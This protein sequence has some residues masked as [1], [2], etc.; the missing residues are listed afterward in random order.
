[1]PKRIKD[2]TCQERLEKQFLNAEDPTPKYFEQVASIIDWVT[3]IDEKIDKDTGKT[4]FIRRKLSGNHKTLYRV[5]LQSE[6]NSYCYKTTRTLAY[7]VGCSVGT[8]YNAKQAL[9][10]PIEQFAGMSL[11][12]I[13]KVMTSSYA[14]KENGVN[15]KTNKKISDHITSNDIWKYNNSY[16]S[17]FQLKEHKKNYPLGRMTD[18]EAE[19]AIEAYGGKYVG[20]A[21]K[22]IE[23][24]LARSEI[25]HADKARSEIEHASPE[26]CSIIESNHTPSSNQTPYDESYSLD[27][28]KEEDHFRKE[29]RKEMEKALKTWGVYRSVREKLLTKYPLEMLSFCMKAL[30]NLK[31]TKNIRNEGS[32]LLKMIKEKGLREYNIRY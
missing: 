24:D 22:K 13:H 28:S 4:V 2:L 15:I 26:A 9:Q 21:L 12:E 14:E 18:E 32:Y 16:M 19:K 1:M 3:F 6:G 30:N 27:K 29:A 7:Q 11:I 8:V 23:N 20:G 25:E 10:M 31:K 17:V 5:I